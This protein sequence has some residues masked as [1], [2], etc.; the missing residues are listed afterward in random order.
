[1]VSGEEV[2]PV[3]FRESA[4]HLETKR[5][6]EHFARALPLTLTTMCALCLCVL[7]PSLLM[8]NT[9]DPPGSSIAWRLALLAV[10]AAGARFSWL[11]G[12][13]EP[14][15][16]EFSFWTFTYVFMGLA[17]MIQL[18]TG[19]DPNTTPGLHAEL[20]TAAMSVVLLG[21]AAAWV[22]I[23]SKPP[24]LRP[25]VDSRVNGLRVILLTLGSLILDAYYVSRIGFYSLFQ[26]WDT[27]SAVQAALWPDQTTRV[28][29]VATCTMPMLVSFI[30]LLKFNRQR[31]ALGNKPLILL[32]AITFIALLLSVNPI[33]STRYY[34]GTVALSAAAALGAYS[35]V[36]RVRLSTLTFLLAL[37]F[38]FPI[39]DVFRRAGATKDLV[40][41]P[42]S[43]MTT[44]DFDA[45]GQINNTLYFV[46][47]FGVTWG[48][49]ALGVLT[50]W[51]PRSVW[52]GKPMDTGIVLA[53]SRDYGFTILS[54]PLWAE[55]FINGG[56]IVVGIGMFVLGRWMREFD[57]RRT[58]EVSSGR[59]PSILSTIL[60]FYLIILLRGSLLQAMAY[61]AVLTVSAVFVRARCM[62]EP[63]GH[64]L[65]LIDG[66]VG[67]QSGTARPSCD[68][69]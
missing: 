65:G 31:S 38:V 15:L 57:A 33:S 1:M 4:I 49:Q 35:N 16:F 60:P 39:A 20:N 26:R 45:F 12:L 41:D 7:G 61:L 42:I 53:Q 68:P 56:W 25:A 40:F 24:R 22:G 23:L 13:G 34:S 10:I 36:R 54:A 28:I 50:F 14:R 29:I 47:R 11:V 8:A 19:I 64:L 69:P 66:G 21:V 2:E 58:A 51:V 67:A 55:L 3:A 27:L 46:E 18:R 62:R 17:P 48:R 63:S 6:S 44:G 30:A 43:S 32:P 5:K 59:P 52:S 9:P 37:V